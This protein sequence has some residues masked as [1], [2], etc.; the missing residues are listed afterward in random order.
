M[1]VMR[2]LATS[3]FSQ[4]YT[5]SL[6][7]QHLYK[8]KKD[9][10]RNDVVH[11]E[12]AEN[13]GL[14]VYWKILKVAE[15]PSLIFYALGYEIL[16]FD[17]YINGQAHCHIQLIE[18]QKKSRSRLFLPEK[19]VE[20]QIERSIFELQNNLNYW[21]Q[22]HPDSQVRKLKVD[23]SKLQIATEKSQGKMLEYAEKIKNTAQ[24]TN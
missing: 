19:T 17:T 1:S 20:E 12:I 16:R 24:I 22:R 4:M 9:Q 23:K 6:K 5:R 2:D 14:E 18:C 21:L 13:V 11:F 8:S 10:I 3:I 7:K 15:G